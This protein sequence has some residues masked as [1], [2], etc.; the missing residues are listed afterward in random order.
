[1]ARANG[2]EAESMLQISNRELERVAQLRP[3][4]PDGTRVLAFDYDSGERY[5]SVDALWSGA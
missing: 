3:E 4:M 2:V 5:L 1:M